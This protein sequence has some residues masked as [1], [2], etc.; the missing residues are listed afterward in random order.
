MLAVIG[1]NL[2]VAL[3]GLALLLY[4][5][6]GLSSF[7]PRPL[8]PYHW[9]IAP[10]A[11]YCLL[12]VVTQFLTNSPF[13][14]TALRSAL[15][16]FLLASVPNIYALWRW[17]R[18]PRGR[19][20]WRKRPRTLLPVILLA[21]LVF[22]LCVLP[23][24]SYGYTTII[25]EN[26][27]AEIY[28]G[29]GEYLKIYSQS[30]LAAALPNPILDTLIN[31][32]Y[33][34]RTHGF[35]Y[36]QAALGFLPLDSFHT[37]APVLALLRA[38]SIPAIY[39]FFRETFRFRPNAALLAS[40][41]LAL[42][43]F[44]LWV[45]YNMF[46]MQV[47]TFGLLP[48]SLCLSVLALRQGR[49]VVR[50]TL[51][52]TE[53]GEDA[54]PGENPGRPQTPDQ[55]D[56]PA[57]SGS[58]T[59]L[60]SAAWSGLFVAALAVTYHPALT[61]YIAMIG[62]AALVLLLANRRASSIRGVV[63]SGATIAVIGIAL[64]LVS[65]LKSF[66][67]FLKQYSEKIGGLGL[68]GF[69]S[70]ADA[71]GFSLSFRDLLPS[72]PGRPLMTLIAQLYSL[73]GWG[74][75]PVALGLLL[76]YIYRT[77]RGRA[78]PRVES[79]VQA[80]ILAGA[81]VYVLLFLRP[82]NYPYGWFKALSFVSF[83]LVGASAGGLYFL[84]ELSPHVSPENDGQRATATEATTTEAAPGTSIFRR[85]PAIPELLAAAAMLV[86]ILVTL[87]L[88]IGMY[89]GTPLR[90]DRSMVEAGAARD[91]VMREGRGASVL[92][93]SSPNMQKL[94]RLYYGLLSYFLRDT[95]LYGTYQTANSKL[96]RE[97]PNGLY[98]YTLLNSEDSPSEYGVS[99]ATLAWH[100]SLMSL[101]ASPPAAQRLDLYHHDFRPDGK[102]PTVRAGGDPVSFAVVSDT[103]QLQDTFSTDGRA[104]GAESRQVT[105]G[106]ASLVTSTLRVEWFDT[107]DTM[108]V[109]NVT[110]P[111]GYTQYRSPG[112]VRS[113]G[114]VRLSLADGSP[115]DASVY[116]RWAHLEKYKGISG[117]EP[118]LSSDGPGL[119][120]AVSSRRTGK[121]I[122]LSV[123]YLNN[124]PGALT[125]TLSLDIYGANKDPGAHYGYW[126]FEVPAGSP[127]RLDLTLDAAR[128]KLSATAG[129]SNYAPATAFDG[130]TG[131]G[132]YV[133]S[134]LVYENGHVVET[135]ND[136]F[137]FTISG[138]A[139]SDFKPRDLPPLF[140]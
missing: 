8:A 30:G 2:S 1:E 61:A 15:I 74:A 57:S 103:L 119:I 125:Q 128:T 45:T 138:K 13:G 124:R 11:G 118:G 34:L 27:D 70:P 19:W 69:T 96:D 7:L 86:P 80:A 115:A 28:M 72:N 55:V 25:G 58:R 102:Y 22:V 51:P 127:T 77:L 52:T 33:S 42:N 23:L 114:R 35:S 123:G 131:E 75:L 140:R 104:S 39:V 71:F 36:F 133:A 14:I 46:G 6:A 113:P 134:L 89:W 106:L 10:W 91:I 63:L 66:E 78:L 101:Y 121:D 109:Q 32:P 105:F 92:V 83:A 24:W 87:W 116:V 126:N 54:I 37:L 3:V 79:W 99:N 62:P 48:L 93:G 82:L 12:V 97:S 94:G 110:V 111:P 20:A 84:M 31:P 100:N 81:V 95:D 21:L 139:L 85:L 132:R 56:A 5:G 67:G 122:E 59:W 26:W 88:T 76:L 18:A 68:T 40:G 38:L 90:Y 49:E 107:S 9:L 17:L 43:A 64:S 129:G 44:L 108:L 53:G 112:S 29:L 135:F 120:A 16:A 130:A 47:P 50:S 73:L 4:L 136:L 137:T 98:R 60:L 41:G 65:Q 117:Q